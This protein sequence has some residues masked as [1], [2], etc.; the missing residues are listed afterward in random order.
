MSSI[1]SFLY[2]KK[3]YIIGAVVF[4]LGGLSALGIQ[5]PTEVYALLGG[6][7]LTTLRAGVGK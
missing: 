6:L 3:T 5:I 4:I 7:G 2:G 1:R